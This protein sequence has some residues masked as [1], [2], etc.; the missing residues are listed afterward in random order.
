MIIKIYTDGSLNIKNN[1][2]AWSF[3][4]C[5]SKKIVKKSGIKKDVSINN[6]EL[7]AVN[8]A[9]SF[10]ITSGY[11]CIEILTDSSYVYNIIKC[12][13]Y[14]EWRKKRW[15]RKNGKNI[16]NYKEWKRFCELMNLSEKYN[17][18]VCFTK[19]KAHK[20]NSMNELA[21]KIAKERLKN[22]LE[23]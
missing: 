5:E 14:E 20:N 19:V 2:G 1:I 21:D 22:F 18:I 3:V 9:L 15:I 11:K 8:E 17:M 4:V 10:S 6:L 7:K 13:M 16:K 23:V 12:K